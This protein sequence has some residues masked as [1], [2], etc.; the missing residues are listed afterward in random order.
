[1]RGFF[2]FLL[3]LILLPIDYA[4]GAAM[5]V[6]FSSGMPEDSFFSAAQI[7]MLI[8]GGVWLLLWAFCKHP[9]RLYVFGHESTHALTTM[10]FGG[11]ASDFHV[12]KNGGSVRVSK[13]NIVVT[14]APYCVPFYTVVVLLAMLIA[15][16]WISVTP[17]TRLCFPPTAGDVFS[18][19]I[20]LTWFF[21]LTFTISSLGIRQP[22]CATYGATLSYAFILGVNLL[23]LGLWFVATTDVELHVW[24]GALVEHLI[25]F[26]R[27][28]KAGCVFLVSCF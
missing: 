21:H 20:G 2:L 25:L 5:W 9:M 10:L 23:I 14:L 11:R 16:F 15:S 28:V 18:F 3:G 4:L 19:F 22:D 12:S 1:M 17:S 24:T 7:W 6:T 8:G 26:C 27:A 13:D